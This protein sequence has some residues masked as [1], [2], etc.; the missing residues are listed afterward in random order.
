[1]SP[2]RQGLARQVR[3]AGKRNASHPDTGQPSV[4]WGWVGLGMIETAPGL[5]IPSSELYAMASEI[6]PTDFRML[7]NTRF[8]RSNRLR[9]SSMKVNW[10]RE[11]TVVGW[12]SSAL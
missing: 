11:R 12:E 3:L 5:H 7:P 4:R 8:G 1:M 10:R 6:A 9:M 2:A